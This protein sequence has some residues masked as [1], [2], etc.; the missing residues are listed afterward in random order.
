MKGVNQSLM[1]QY[2][3]NYDPSKP[4]SDIKSMTMNMDDCIIRG[5]LGPLS[6]L[7]PANV[8]P[9][10]EVK[11]KTLKEIKA[12]PKVSTINKQ[13]ADIEARMI[14]ASLGALVAYALTR[15][16]AIGGILTGVGDIIK[17]AGEIVPF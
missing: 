1:Q 15:P 6:F 3:K 11:Y 8:F 14:T 12:D 9:I 13:L 10:V 16:G 4:Q 2:I 7:L 17:G 5:L